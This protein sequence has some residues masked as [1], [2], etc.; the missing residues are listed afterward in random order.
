MAPWYFDIGAGDS[1]LTWTGMAGIGYHFD[2]GEVVL[3]YRYMDYDMGSGSP[4]RDIN[5]AGPMIGA[6]FAW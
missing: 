3:T 1:D 4:I 5:F 2:W 6:S